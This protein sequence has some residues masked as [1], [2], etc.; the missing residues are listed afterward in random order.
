MIENNWAQRDSPRKR[1][2]NEQKK[3]VKKTHKIG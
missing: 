3:T 1:K 2:Q